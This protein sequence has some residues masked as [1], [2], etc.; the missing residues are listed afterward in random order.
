MGAL[1]VS[2]HLYRTGY[3]PRPRQVAQRLGLSD[4]RN[5][6][7][8]W[9]EPRNFGDWIGPYLFMKMTGRVPYH[10]KPRPRQRSRACSTATVGSIMRHI[11]VDDRVD[12][13]GSG[14]ISASDEFARPRRVLAVRGPRTRQRLQEMDL[15]TTEVFGDPALLMPRFYEPAARPDRHALG[16]IPHFMDHEKAVRRF[17]GIEGVKVIDVTRPIEDVVDDIAA[18]DAA[19]S[20]SL[21]GLILSHAYGVPCAWVASESENPGDG[22]KYADYLESIGV[23]GIRD[24]APLPLDPTLRDLVDI[25]GSFPSGDPVK[26]ADDLLQTCPFPC[27]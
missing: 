12:V 24:P 23:Y 17:G 8:S 11:V 15:P 16:V 20:S 6:L 25:A 9:Y 18:C 21:H 13:W 7:W 4:R 26:L 2:D 10:C 27:D 3:T 19:L 1:D 22:V 14:I 5:L